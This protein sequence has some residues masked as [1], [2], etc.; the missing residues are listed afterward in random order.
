MKFTMKCR[1]S[2]GAVLLSLSAVASGAAIEK[3]VVGNGTAGN[4]AAVNGA[5]GNGAAGSGYGILAK[6]PGPDG[7]W[8]YATISEHRL[9]LAQ[10]DNISI[11][12]LGATTAGAP[13]PAWT[14]I[15]VPGATWHGVLPLESRGLLLATNGQAHAVVM[16][17]ARTHDT[18]A[19]V[20]THPGRPSA[21]TGKMALFAGLADPDALVADP[22]SGLV[23]AVNGGSG[24]VVFVD[25]DRKAVVG[26]ARVGGK[27]EFAVA[28]GKGSLYLNVQNAHSIAVIDTH[29]F[30]VTRRMTLAGCV[31]PKGLA[32]DSGTDLLISGCNNGIAKFIIAQTGQRLASMKVG[33]GS[34]AVMIDG[35]RHRAFVASGDDAVLS[36]F[37]IGDPRHIALLQTLSTEPGVRLGAVDAQT[38]ILYLPSGTL[39]P[40]IAPRPWPSVLPGTFHVLVV[41]LNHP[42]Q[43]R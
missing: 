13:A 5:A 1:W 21:L 4:G 29:T 8:D 40:P 26:R 36:I 18:V 32:Y 23:A 25:V 10:T 35:G 42:P 43:E 22:K 15:H 31:E 27:L 39:G 20:S 41:G 14:Q 19:T 17:D 7:M 24:E 37:D 3:V 34:D 30:T 16:F 28:D 11:L 2:L 33:A 9:Y 12:D 6:I 38:G